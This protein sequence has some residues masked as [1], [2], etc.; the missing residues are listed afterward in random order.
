MTFAL[1]IQK[2]PKAEMDKRVKESL[3]EVQMEGYADRYP[4]EMSDGRAQPLPDLR[5]RRRSDRRAGRAAGH[6]P[7]RAGPEPGAAALAGRGRGRHAARTGITT[8]VTP[9]GPPPRTADTPLKG[10]LRASA[11]RV[12][13]GQGAVP[14]QPPSGLTWVLSRRPK[15][16]QSE[17]EG[18]SA[19]APGWACLQTFGSNYDSHR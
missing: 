6:A 12:P 7:R 8:P 14:G 5:P 16:E 10:V 15:R 19:A 1:E 11:G 4:R 17:R 18:R 3:A 9:S 2:L 13:W